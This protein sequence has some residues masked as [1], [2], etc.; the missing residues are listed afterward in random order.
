MF[1]SQKKLDTVMEANRVSQE[2]LKSA[3]DASPM[4]KIKDAIREIN[5]EGKS[6]LEGAAGE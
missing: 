2:R 3:V 5:E 6:A 1:A 4:D